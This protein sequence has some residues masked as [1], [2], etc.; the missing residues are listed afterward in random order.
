MFEQIFPT[1]LIEFLATF[2]VNITCCAVLFVLGRYVFIKANHPIE[3]RRVF[4]YFWFSRW[5]VF[6]LIN[7]NPI[8]LIYEMLMGKSIDRLILTSIFL[9]EGIIF[10]SSCLGVKNYS[11]L[12]SSKSDADERLVLQIAWLFAFI[13]LPV[14]LYV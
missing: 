5:T 7:K 6:I 9:I 12:S 1:V 2:L 8:L 11:S 14:L 4:I 10:I 13:I 3:Y